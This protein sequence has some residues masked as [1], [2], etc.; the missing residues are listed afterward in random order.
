MTGLGV[1]GLG[2][3][4]VEIERFRLALTRSIN[5]R[6]RLFSEAEQNYAN[7]HK[8][9]TKSLAARFAAKEA[10]M[11]A[12]GVGLGDFAFKDVE[13]VR[14]KNGAPSIA[15]RGRAKTLANEK[16]VSSWHVSLTHTDT[17]ALAVVLA[18]RGAN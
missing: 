10:V 4:L 13:V 17:A 2:S 5:L 1:V 15:L 3:D 7:T 6:E 11:K 18:L 12:L 14:T 9:P 8:D 16:G